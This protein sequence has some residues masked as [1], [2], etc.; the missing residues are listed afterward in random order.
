MAAASNTNGLASFS[1]PATLA[2]QLDVWRR[3]QDDLPGRAEAI[4][5]LVQIGL[6]SAPTRTPGKRASAKSTAMAGAE[7]D[8]LQHGEGSTPK[9]DADRKRRLLKGP[10]EF[11]NM[12]AR[13]T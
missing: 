9:Q 6:A 8:R 2:K 13:G 12:R 10:K 5:R 4:R 3:R 7:I 1:I 11:R